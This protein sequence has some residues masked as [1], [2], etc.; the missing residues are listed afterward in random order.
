MSYPGEG[1]RVRNLSMEQLIEGFRPSSFHKSP[2]KIGYD[3]LDERARVSFSEMPSADFKKLLEDADPEFMNAIGPAAAFAL[4][5][6]TKVRAT[7]VREG[8][9]VAPIEA[10]ISPGG[11]PGVV[12][13]WNAVEGGIALTLKSGFPLR[14]VADAINA[15]PGAKAAIEHDRLIVRGIE[16]PK[17]LL[18]LEAIEVRRPTLPVGAIEIGKFILGVPAYD[19]AEKAVYATPAAKKLLGELAQQLKGLKE[20]RLKELKD[21]LSDFNGAKKAQYS[22]YGEA[23][24]WMLTG[25]HDG[26]PLHH[27]MAILGKEETAK[28]LAAMLG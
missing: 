26:L 8:R 17:L 15:I 9:P 3:R 13:T 10:L 11:K 25:S 19:D 20:W 22:E 16:E 6:A 24:R 5:D 4:A 1:E 12:Q 14:E 2:A 7:T 28:R 18:A 21:A 23:L 27:T